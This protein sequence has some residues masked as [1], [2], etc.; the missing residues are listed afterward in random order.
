MFKVKLDENTYL[1]LLERQHAPELFQVVEENREML[2]RWL[3]FPNK[4]NS[5]EDSE[6]FIDRS[7]KR[8]ESNNGFWAGIW[9]KGELAG[10]I[11]FLYVD[12]NNHKTEIG[13]WLGSKFEGKG[14][15]TSACNKFINHSFDTWGLNKAE[16]NMAKGNI[17]SRAVAERLGLKEEGIIRDYEFLNDEYRDRVFYGVLKDE[18]MDRKENRR[19]SQ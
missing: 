4:T 10:A 19:E 11:G 5:V 3:S 9:H 7:M 18:W 6:Q 17:R 8:H 13:Y 14:L 2:K 12:W 16:I 1:S 15:V